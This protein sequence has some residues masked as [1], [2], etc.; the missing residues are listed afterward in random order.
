MASLKRRS[1]VAERRPGRSV[2]VAAMERG[3]L[4]E[5]VRALSDRQREILSAVIEPLPRSPALEELLEA[6]GQFDEAQVRQVGNV[7]RAMARQVQENL[8]PYSDLVGHA[9]AHEFRARLQAHHGTHTTVMDRLA[10][11]NALEAAC[12]AEGKAVEPAPSR[13]TRFWDVRI[14]GAQT[15]AK[16]TAASDL[17]VDTLH[18]SKLSEAAWIQDCRSA[19]MRHQKTMQ[20]FEEFLAVVQRWIVLRAFRVSSGC[21]YE[22]V[23]I[24]VS[25]FETVLTL[26]VSE[27]SS[28]A[29][30]ILIEDE[31]GIV[32]QLVLDRSDSKV[33]IGRIP[34]SRCIVHGEWLVRTS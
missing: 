1:S 16:S 34:K 3:E 33:T 28:D 22:L 12:R 11:E 7:A 31:Q 4:E 10:F 5:L 26:P 14:D 30:R 32:F 17:K 20:L 27:F 8:D 6:V 19:R 9:F 2:I 24:P 18:I 13:T 23:E 21:R 15:S 29:P 25:L